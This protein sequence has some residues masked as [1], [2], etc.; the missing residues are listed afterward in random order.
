MRAERRCDGVHRRRYPSVRATLKMQKYSKTEKKKEKKK[1]KNQRFYEIAL[2]RT[3]YSAVS[4]KSP[5]SPSFPFCSV[6]RWSR[7]TSPEITNSMHWIIQLYG[8]AFHLHTKRTSIFTSV[9]RNGTN[10]LKQAEVVIISRTGRFLRCWSHR[11]E[12]VGINWRNC[13][14]LLRSWTLHKCRRWAWR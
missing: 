13:I 9:S 3:L 4:I 14:P 8:F 7:C 5:F 6:T 1:E 11:R 2:E 10:K 12:P